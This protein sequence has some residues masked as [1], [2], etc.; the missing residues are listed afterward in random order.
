MIGGEYLSMGE[1]VVVAPA[2][3]RIETDLWEGDAVAV[4]TVIGRVREGDR[5]VPLLSP[6]AGIFLGW[7]ARSGEWVPPG[8]AV[9]RLRAS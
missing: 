7:L 6:V 9:A 3:G 5:V 4:G 1:R 2:W 8:R